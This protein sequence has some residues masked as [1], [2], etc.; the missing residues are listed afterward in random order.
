MN[1]R[2]DDTSDVGQI[3]SQRFG[4]FTKSEKQ[5]AN[6]LLNNQD[7]LAFLA[8]AE[9][10]ERLDLSEAT[11][12]RFARTLGYESY[13]ALRAALQQKFRQRVTHSARIRSRLDDLRLEGDLFERLVVSEIDYMTQALET[14]DRSALRQAEQ[15]LRAHERTFVFGVGPSASLVD[16]MNIR[17]TRFGRQVIP[18]TTAG[19]EILEPLLL[20]TASDLLFAICFFDVSQ[21]MQLV[22][23]YANEVGCPVI[24]LTDTLDS[25]IGDR[26]QVVLAA[27]R[28]PVSEFHSLVVPMT[29]INSLLLAL[30][31]EDQEN[32]L[33]S[34][35][36]LDKLRDRL[37]KK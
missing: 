8:A 33:A 23:D 24:L 35:D 6:Y 34:L 22:L 5:I 20:M 26:A 21:A 15:L 12:V 31:D 28:G 17:L 32:V 29:I 10:A 2:T 18:L 9:L 36:K 4:D 3:I 27:K 30:A 14:V 19:R 16:L 1:T 25:I 13:P 7:E 11:I 37:S